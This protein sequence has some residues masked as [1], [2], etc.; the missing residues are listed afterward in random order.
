MGLA[1]VR[2]LT[3]SFEPVLPQITPGA[4]PTSRGGYL[5]EDMLEDVQHILAHG[6]EATNCLWV[7]LKKLPTLTSQMSNLHTFSFSVKWEKYVVPPIGF[8][9]EH[10]AIYDIVHSLPA[11]LQNLELDTKAQENTTGADRGW[12]ICTTIGSRLD[13]LSH[14]RLR[15]KR[16]CGKLFRPSTTL[17]TFSVSM[18]EPLGRSPDNLRCDDDAQY[19]TWR[20]GRGGRQQGRKTRNELIEAAQDLLV[21]EQLPS[22]Q[23]LVLTEMK[24]H[25]EEDSMGLMLVRDIK[26]S[27]T[28]AMPIQN[29]PETHVLQL[30]LLSDD[31]TTEDAAGSITNLTEAAEGDLWVT[32]EAGSRFP[33]AYRDSVEGQG[34][35]WSARNSYE[36]KEQFLARNNGEKVGW[37]KEEDEVG[38]RLLE[39]RQVDGLGEVEPIFK[40]KTKHQRE[41]GEDRDSDFELDFDEDGNQIIPTV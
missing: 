15:L 27:K 38:E 9:L 13:H 23:K 33:A 5:P 29:V 4:K 1:L 25:E 31:S 7:A 39:A 18:I 22:L 19:R 14:V 24:D 12:N 21:L 35:K 6:N 30:R 17:K 40:G 36:T 34:H 3:I 16:Y 41:F 11:S 20:H 2:S 8:W 37:W 26:N 10:R 32:T 28:I